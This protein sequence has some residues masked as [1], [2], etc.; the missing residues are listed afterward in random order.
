MAA[1]LFGSGKPQPRRQVSL[2]GDH[3][4]AEEDTMAAA[5]E[6]SAVEAE[7]DLAVEAEEEEA[8]SKTVKFQEGQ[9][10]QDF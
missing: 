4:E 9:G 10:T 7:V 1:L 2:V 6:D 8:F 5:E 3:E